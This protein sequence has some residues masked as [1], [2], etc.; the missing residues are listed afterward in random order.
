MAKELK[1]CVTIPEDVK[2]KLK[3]FFE[4]RRHEELTRI[5]LYEL[6]NILLSSGQRK[7]SQIGQFI[8]SNIEGLV[9]EYASEYEVWEY[10]ALK[11]AK[12]HKHGIPALMMT[13]MYYDKIWTKT[14]PKESK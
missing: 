12:E 8:R 1:L 11:Y 10:K 9:R 14:F 4:N 3:Y 13:D 2:T 6:A 5:A 7:K